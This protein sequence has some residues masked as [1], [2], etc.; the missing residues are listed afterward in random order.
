MKRIDEVIAQLKE[1]PSDSFL[2]YALGLEYLKINNLQ[3][4]I[5][6]FENLIHLHPNYLATY[7]QLGKCYE[8]INDFHNA[9]R[10]YK[11]GM[12]LAAENGDFKTKGE[13]YTAINLIED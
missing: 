11:N 2:N 13:L 6:I 10:V 4:S 1:N 12:M 8:L 7:Y 3:K 9:I 5:S